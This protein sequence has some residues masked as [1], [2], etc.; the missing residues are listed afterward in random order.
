MKIS[1]LKNY[2]VV[3]GA[4]PVSVS[5]AQPEQPDTRV[6]LS[7]GK[8]LDPL[9]RGVQDVIKG[10][11]DFTGATA[12]GEGLGTAAYNASQLPKEFNKLATSAPGTY[13][14]GFAPVDVPKM[15]GG[16]IQ[17]GANFAPGAGA[18]AGLATKVGLGAATG[19]A[20]D[21]GTK[22]QE[23]KGTESFIPGF[24]T[25][26]GAGLPLVGAGIGVAN[27]MVSRLVKGLGSGLSGVSTEAIDRIVSNPER[28]LEVSRN[29]AKTGNSRVLE[30]NARDIVNGVSKIR[31]EARS[32]FGEGL[33][34]LKAEDI[35]PTKFRDSIQSFLDSNGVSLNAKTNVRN[36]ENVE[37]SDPKNLQRASD[38]IDE[39]SKTKLDGLSLRNLLKKVEDTRFKT[40]TSDERL[41]FNAFT[42]DLAESIKGAISGSTDK[43]GEINK[44]FSQDMQLAEATQNIFGKVNFKNLPEVVKASQKLESLF[45]QK[46]LA[47]QVVDDFLTRIGINPAD[48]KTGEAVRQITNKA[49][50]ANTKGLSV[51]E[52]MQQATS[53]IITP[54]MVKKIAIGT[55]MA[56]QRLGS[57][58]QELAPAARN[59]VIEG[60]LKL[61]Q[62]SQK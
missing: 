53:A 45:S 25:A 54:E 52:I 55:G 30:Q 19:Y 29:I 47:P 46:G 39:L 4:S 7:T 13:K 22:L 49:S 35:N 27:K 12:I 33:Q 36:L 15:A 17:A 62:E 40:A 23:G 20:F 16:I 5:K 21:V 10:F 58:L 43:L 24:G 2:T 26:V 9:S 57:F 48:F 61:N 1:D 14:S 32:A 56:E 50:G 8:P 44:A 11:G 28:A 6:D 59:I 37:F 18:G 42:K 60:L 51:G 41:A 38:L 3:S 31:Q 34:K